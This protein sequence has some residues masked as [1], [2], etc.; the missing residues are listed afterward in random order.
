MAYSSW[1]T[2][3][4]CCWSISARLSYMSPYWHMLAVTS[5]SLVV[6][7]LS[8]GA[9]AGAAVGVVSLVLSQRQC[10]W[11]T[12]LCERPE[13]YLFSLYVYLNIFINMF[14]H[15]PA[16]P[17]HMKNTW[18]CVRA[19]STSKC[20]QWKNLKK[21]K[22]GLT[23]NIHNSIWNNIQDRKI[24]FIYKAWRALYTNDFFLDRTYFFLSYGFCKSVS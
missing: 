1:R 18:K 13:N 5:A 16:W 22:L 6:G 23:Y 2:T 24:S 15:P 20:V 12:W 10:L 21:W 14:F 19:L 8:H 9:A 7:E 17:K 3:W 4:L 11:I